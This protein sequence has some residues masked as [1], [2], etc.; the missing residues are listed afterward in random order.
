MTRWYRAPELI[1]LEKDYGP[2]IDMWAIGCIMGELFAMIK[3]PG[4]SSTFLDRQ[5]LFQ[6][7]SCFP[8]SPTMKKFEEIKGFP[9]TNSD[10]LSKIF[11]LLGTPSKEDRSFVTDEKAIEYLGSFKSMSRLNFSE[12]YPGISKDGIDFLE[13]LL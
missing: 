7:Q 12:R 9:M 5:P 8:L 1:L 4:A 11:S 6:G 10:Q 13:N 2:A 3:Q